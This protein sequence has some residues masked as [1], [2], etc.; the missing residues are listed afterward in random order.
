M[1][2]QEEN[3]P[4]VVQ[5]RLRKLA[6]FYGL[7]GDGDWKEL[8]GRRGDAARRLRVVFPKDLPLWLVNNHGMNLTREEDRGSIEENVRR[9]GVRLLVIDPLYLVCGSVGLASERELHPILQWLLWLRYELDCAVVL[10]HHFRKSDTTLD[11]RPV[12]HGQRLL[13]SMTLHAW[14]EC[15]M[16][17]E[18]EPA[19]R[20]VLKTTIHREF[21][22]VGVRAPLKATIEMG[23]PGSLTFNARIGYG[24]RVAEIVEYV[25]AQVDKPMRVTDLTAAVKADKRTVMNAIRKLTEGGKF[26]LKKQGVLWYVQPRVEGR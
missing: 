11:G 7:I 22:N 12:R 6:R 14:L 20:G 18:S 10:V 26:E 16:Y 25:N 8:R 9:L 1:V 3:A 5:D 19:E 24:S 23:E 15:G 17:C 21:R 2:I 13:G 4:W